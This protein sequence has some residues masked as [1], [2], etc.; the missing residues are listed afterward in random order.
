[1][2]RRPPE[3]ELSASEASLAPNTAEASCGAR[4]WPRH[5]CSNHPR[6]LPREPFRPG[7]GAKRPRHAVGGCAQFAAWNR[8]PNYP[9][10][11]KITCEYSAACTGR[12][13]ARAALLR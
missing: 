13:Q 1:M 11:P 7:T 8:V 10:G 2:A 3:H 4:P 12:E 9:G 6:A 5:P